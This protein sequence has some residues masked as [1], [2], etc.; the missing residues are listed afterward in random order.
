MPDPA[1][2]EAIRE[3]YAAVPAGV[4][5]LHTIEIRHP[6]FDAPIRVVRNFAD[7]ETWLALDEPGVT[8]VLDGLDAETRD[9]VGLVARLEAS[10]PAD[11]GVLVPW[12]ALGFQMELPQVESIAVPEITLT[13]DNVGEEIA[14]ALEGAA[15]SQDVIEVTYRPYLSTDIEGPQMD[16]PITLILSDVEADLYQVTG[17]ARLLDIGNLAFPRRTYKPGEFP[18]LVA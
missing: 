11:P 18:G 12:I 9:M 13:I 3:A 4:V 8:A 15:T 1:L 7:T 10:A 17:K 14:E 2:S 6:T 16:P 5:T